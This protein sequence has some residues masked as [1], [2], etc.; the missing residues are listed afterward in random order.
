M[1]EIAEQSPTKSPRKPYQFQPGNNA[2]PYGRKGKKEAK[3]LE[4]LDKLENQ[5]DQI[6]AKIHEAAG[7]DPGK[8]L[9]A[10]GLGMVKVA[11]ELNKLVEK[12]KSDTVKIRT[13]ELAA[14]IH[15]MIRDDTQQSGGITVIIQAQQGPQQINLHAPAPTCQD[16]YHQPE[17][18][19]PTE[20]L[21]ITK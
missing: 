18:S 15:K 2:N 13:L 21:I 14:K 6:N 5:A 1:P 7:P 20:P 16:P 4:Q 12:S 10:A 17:P 3:E 9:R 19:D 11:K 8:V